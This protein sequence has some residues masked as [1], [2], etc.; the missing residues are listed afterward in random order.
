M[1][2][3]FPLYLIWG[4]IRRALQVF[5][6]WVRCSLG[7]CRWI[8]CDETLCWW[9][10][11][12]P[13]DYSNQ[14]SIG[15]NFWSLLLV[16]SWSRGCSLYREDWS[17]EDAIHIHVFKKASYRNSTKKM[18]LVV[19]ELEAEHEDR[20]IDRRPGDCMM[21]RM[22]GYLE[23]WI[24]E[25][26]GCDNEWGLSVTKVRF[27]LLNGESCVVGTSLSTSITSVWFQS[28]S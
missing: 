19:K 27:M 1:L 12:L 15:T 9:K 25:H 7:E 6:L 20:S 2:E 4:R 13:A 26:V 8:V 5:A 23:P 3:R 24:C 21:R 18:G 28:G 11:T 22:I 16:L 17:A 14:A 10:S